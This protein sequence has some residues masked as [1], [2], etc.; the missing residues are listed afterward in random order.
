MANE[1]VVYLSTNQT[2]N[3][4]TVQEILTSH[5]ETSQEESCN[6]I[7]RSSCYKNEI[8]PKN[9]NFSFMGLVVPNKL[10]KIHRNEQIDNAKNLARLN[11]ESLEM[12]CNAKLAELKKKLENHVTRVLMAE[13]KEIIE[14]GANLIN[15]FH[16]KIDSKQVAFLKNSAKKLELIAQSEG[17]PL[18]AERL[19]QQF[20]RD[21]NRHFDLMNLLKDEIQDLLKKR[22]SCLEGGKS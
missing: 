15:E 21:T 2:D 12:A 8:T 20:E 17:I 19:K 3:D 14:Y 5:K 7:I 9:E 13:D 1:N 4:S 16:E 6:S 10:E 18:V 11:V 22:T